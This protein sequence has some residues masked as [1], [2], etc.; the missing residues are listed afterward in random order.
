MR[1][2]ATFDRSK[3]AE[4]ILPVLQRIAALPNVTFILLAVAELPA[5]QA[6][7][8]A[9]NA[10]IG[11]DIVIIKPPPDKHVETKSQAIAGQVSALEDYLKDIA[12]Q[13]PDGSSYS[14]EAHVVDHPAHMIIERA[15]QEAP[16]V[17]VMTTHGHTGLV[18]SLFGSVTDEVV[19]SGVAPVL[20]VHPRT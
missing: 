11:G 3:Y 1:I 5:G 15:R 2:M 12:K 17:I 14:I 9:A 13:L 6:P 19:R 4:A 10:V 16:A 8:T 18:R 20:V 7:A